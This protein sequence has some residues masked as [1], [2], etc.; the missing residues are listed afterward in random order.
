MTR[1]F[2]QRRTSTPRAYLANSRALGRPI[3]PLLLVINT[4]QK[5]KKRKRK[6]KRIAGNSTKR[7]CNFAR[8]LRSL[9]FSPFPSFS[10]G[11]FPSTFPLGTSPSL[12]LAFSFFRPLSR[13]LHEHAQYRTRMHLRDAGTRNCAR[14][15]RARHGANIW[16][17]VNAAQT[18]NTPYVQRGGSRNAALRV[19]PAL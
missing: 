15:L 18:E 7:S 11:L 17:T 2:S 14:N 6:K 12:S 5:K 16:A 1:S 10:I 8:V 3:Q 13:R 9:S 4:S 19:K